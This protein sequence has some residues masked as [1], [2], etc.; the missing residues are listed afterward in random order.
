MCQWKDS[1]MLG[2]TFM[3][4]I[5]IA[6]IERRSLV[7]RQQREVPKKILY[8]SGMTNVFPVIQETSVI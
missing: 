2:F 8:L 1:E 6:R 5:S 7:G 3:G 4:G